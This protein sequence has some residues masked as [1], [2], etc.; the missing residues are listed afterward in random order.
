MSIFDGASFGSMFQ[1]KDGGKAVYLAHITYNDTHKLML[2][3]FEFP[4]IYDSEGVRRSSGR[5]LNPHGDNLDIIKN[6]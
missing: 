1:T 5:Y 3:G 4:V 6:L 2:Q